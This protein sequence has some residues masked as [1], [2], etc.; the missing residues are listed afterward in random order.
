[1]FLSQVGTPINLDA[2]ARDVIAP[3]LAK[4]D[5]RWCGWHAFRRGLATNLHRL[6]VQDKTIQRILRHS[7]VG[8]TQKCYI[9]TVDS[10]AAGDADF[11]AVSQE[12]T[13]YAPR[14]VPE[15]KLKV[16]APK[17]KMLQ[18]L[19]STGFRTSG[20]EGGIRIRLQMSNKGLNRAR[21]AK[22]VHVKLQKT[23]HLICK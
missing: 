5:L 11:R 8:V 20:G 22:L 19:I 13:Q 12:C 10:D 6:G 17:Q 2:M 18:L 14:D 16:E 15:T 1:M 21:T 4:R 23:S 7:N 9:K 3:A